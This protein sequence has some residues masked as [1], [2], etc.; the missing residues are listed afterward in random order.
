MSELKI[1]IPG[2]MFLAGE[3]A[4][5]KAK[6]AAILITVNAFLTIRIQE[7]AQFKCQPRNNSSEQFFSIT[8]QGALTV[9]TD[10][11]KSDPLFYRT[12]EVTCAY[13]HEIKPTCQFRPFSLKVCSQLENASGS[14]YG[15]GSSAA[16]TVGIIRAI[17]C[18]Y[19]VN[20]NHL[21]DT[22]RLTIYKLA[23]LAQ[24][25]LGLGG[26]YADLAAASFTGCIYYQ[27][28]NLDCLNG[29]SFKNKKKI[30]D[31]INIPWPGL[32]IEHLPWPKKWQLL[33][34]WDESPS[35]TLALTADEL[36]GNYHTENFYQAAKIIVHNIKIAIRLQDFYLFKVHY[37]AYLQLIDLY[38]KSRSKPY[39]TDSFKQMQK[40]SFTPGSAWKI[41]GAGGGDCSL[42]ISKNE[43][44]RMITMELLKKQHFTILPYHFFKEGG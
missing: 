4:V 13:I 5:I 41:A 3:Y 42:V 43:Q 31:F 9:A 22:E 24:V 38:T 30:N 1:Q 16:I 20:S 23:V 33:I 11:Y 39:W 44:N 17:L 6:Q 8:H 28:F 32:R 29:W 18:F 14:K 25:S 37:E 40:V 15:L 34:H 26:S 19:G 27:N 7:Q 2:K 36:A 21:N 10:N 12:I 35:S